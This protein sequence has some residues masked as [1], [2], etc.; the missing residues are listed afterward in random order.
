MHVDK[1][2]VTITH[3]FEATRKKNDYRF[4]Q[5]QGRS[6]EIDVRKR[7]NNHVD[8]WINNVN[9]VPKSY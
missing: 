4:L 2:N 5:S 3:F 9:I 7:K 8:M 6:R 1:Y